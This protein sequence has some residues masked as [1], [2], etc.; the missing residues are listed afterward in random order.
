[1]ITSTKRSAVLKRS[2]SALT[3]CPSSICAT[4]S[5][6]RPPSRA[7][8]KRRLRQIPQPVTRALRSRATSLVGWSSA[9]ALQS[10]P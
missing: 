3:A 1:M 6:P 7:P 2:G 5:S 4:R 10:V 9:P 8:A